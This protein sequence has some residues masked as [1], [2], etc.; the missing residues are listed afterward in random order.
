MEKMMAVCRYC[1]QVVQ[2]DREFR[3]EEEA[4]RWAVMHCRCAGALTAQRLESTVAAGKA[5]VRELFG[6]EC[7][8]NELEP[9]SEQTLFL[10]EQ[11]VELLAAGAME[12]VQLTLHDGSKAALTMR[13][14]GTIRVE[15]KTGKCWALEE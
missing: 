15:R 1:G 6:E 4:G 11:A 13:A 10:L 3:S 5:N 12:K 2:T 8:E 7:G 9:V 14:K